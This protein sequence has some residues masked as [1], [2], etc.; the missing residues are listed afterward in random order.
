MPMGF[1]QPAQI[2]GDAQKHGVVV[3][4][5]DINYSEWDN[6]VHPETSF[7]SRF[8]GTTNAQPSLKLAHGIILDTYLSELS[9][10]D[11]PSHREGSGMGPIR[12][13]FRQVKGLRQDDIALLLAGRKERYKTIDALRTAGL[14]D[15]ALER[16]ADADAFRSIGLDRRQALWEVS[17]KD[18]PAAIFSDHP[19]KGFEEEKV[20]LPEMS[21]PEHV[22]HD[23]AT[24][25]L[26]LKA[27]P[28]SFVR[29]QLER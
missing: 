15:A 19:S 14:T 10:A 28:V 23:Y 13:G 3:L 20:T 11:G 8:G 17:T 12:L 27:H 29:D 18:Q 22:A 24:T 5:V 6:T 9:V 25:S 26:S 21:L 2:V 1:Y 16:L 7:R 4:P